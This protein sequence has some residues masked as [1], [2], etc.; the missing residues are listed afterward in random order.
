MIVLFVLGDSQ[1]YYQP[2]TTSASVTP[3]SATTTPSVQ[4][5]YS[6]AHVSELPEAIVSSIASSVQ[7]ELYGQNRVTSSETESDTNHHLSIGQAMSDSSEYFVTPSRAT[8]DDIMVTA[9]N[10]AVNSGPVSLDLASQYISNYPSRED[11]G[12]LVSASEQDATEKL[13]STSSSMV[14]S[15]RNIDQG[16]CLETRK[17]II[18]KDLSANSTSL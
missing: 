14:S 3:S 15:E 13:A 12:I 11:S 2:S 10:D 9:S 1:Q 5:V 7:Q 8:G 4:V 18:S 6:A 17:N 16:I